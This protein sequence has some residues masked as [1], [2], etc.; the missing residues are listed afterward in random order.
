MGNG[1]VLI[2]KY[3]CWLR[4]RTLESENM[5]LSATINTTNRQVDIRYAP[6]SDWSILSL[7]SLF[8]LNNQAQRD[9]AEASRGQQPG[10]F[11]HRGGGAQPGVLH[12]IHHELGTLENIYI[13]KVMR[14]CCDSNSNLLCFSSLNS[15]CQAQSNTK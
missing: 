6:A 15:I 14:I 2:F 13:L 3:F 9:R 10:G 4:L 5:R 8:F 11:L 1:S 7:G 12:L